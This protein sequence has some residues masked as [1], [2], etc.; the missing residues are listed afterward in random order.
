MILKVK[1]KEEELEM[2]KRGYE[3]EME[4]L[5]IRYTEEFM[6]KEE[7]LR[8]RLDLELNKQMEE[9]KEKVEGK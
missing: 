9:V 1:R 2:R 7:D 6:Q 3:V 5:K 8:T 4:E